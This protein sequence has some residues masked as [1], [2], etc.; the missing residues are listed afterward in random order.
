MSVL[1]TSISSWSSIN[2]VLSADGNATDLA[3]SQRTHVTAQAA[4]TAAV[5][6]QDQISVIRIAG[7]PTSSANAIRFRC[8]GVTADTV[9]TYN[10]YSG[11]LQSNPDCELSLLGTLSFTIGTQV[12]TT[13]G[14]ELADQLAVTEGDTSASFINTTSA[15]DERVAETF[16]D[17]QGSDILVIVPTAVGSDCKLLGKLY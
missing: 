11:T 16:I 1:D 6:N 12:S 2:S 4:I 17:L 8:I 7:N 3:V 9:C 5:N 15:A 10:V 13:T 14:Y